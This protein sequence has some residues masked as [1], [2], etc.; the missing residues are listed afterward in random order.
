MTEESGFKKFFRTLAVA[1]TTAFIITGGL[2]VGFRGQTA[3]ERLVERQTL[4][5]NLATA[6]VLTLP[7][8]EQGRDPDL[9]ELCFTQYDLPAPRLHDE[10]P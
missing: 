5:A 1:V 4:N 7:V 8:E 3:A 6:C 2:I 9:V 10:T